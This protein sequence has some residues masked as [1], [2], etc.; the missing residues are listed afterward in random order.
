MSR[1]K[2]RILFDPDDDG[3]NAKASK[4]LDTQTL[5][6]EEMVEWCDGIRSKYWHLADR[7][8]DADIWKLVKNEWVHISQTCSFRGEGES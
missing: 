2:V 4:E 6:V 8:I 3:E 1:Y 7:R 5:T